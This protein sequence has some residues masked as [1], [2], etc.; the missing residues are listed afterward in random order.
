MQYRRID[1]ASII[2]QWDLDR[3]NLI[4]KRFDAEGNELEYD[5]WGIGPDEFNAKFADY[6]RVD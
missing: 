3:E 6:R 4:Y 1:G 5:G 2:A